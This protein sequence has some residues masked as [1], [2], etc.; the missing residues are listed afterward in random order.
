M[1]LRIPAP[2][3]RSGASSPCPLLCDER[4]PPTRLGD[5]SS[6]PQLRRYPVAAAQ[7]NDIISFT[8]SPTPPWTLGPL[9]F[10]AGDG[11]LFSP[12]GR[13]PLTLLS[14]PECGRLL[15]AGDG[16]GKPGWQ[17][18]WDSSGSLDY[19]DSSDSPD[20]S[21]SSDSQ[22]YWDSLDSS[23]SRCFSGSRGSWGH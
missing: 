18:Y 13:L 11:E 10:G 5:F 4:V 21:D 20:C 9:A 17:D 8:I 2:G 22:G 3:P 1:L 12:N 7:R 14:A 23:D 15:S 19:S 16:A 6:L